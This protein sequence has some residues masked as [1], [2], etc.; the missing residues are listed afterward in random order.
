MPTTLRDVRFQ[1]QSGKHMLLAGI[2]PFDPKRTSIFQAETD[3][4]V[5]CLDDNGRR[6]QAFQ[7]NDH[8]VGAPAGGVGD[9]GLT[10]P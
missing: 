7:I 2:S 5:G 1:G 6:T 4:R 3:Q 10:T 8:L 9:T